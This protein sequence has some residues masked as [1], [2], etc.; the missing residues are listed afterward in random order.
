MTGNALG[1]WTAHLSRH[2]TALRDL[3]ARDGAGRPVF[4]LEHDLGEHERR[5][6]GEA[7]RREIAVRPPSDLHWLAW[8]VYSSELGYRYAGDE[9]WQTFERETSGWT[10]RGDRR[11]LRKCFKKFQREYRGAVPSGAWAKHFSIICWPITHAILPKDLQ[12]QFA[13]ILFRLRYTYSGDLFESPLR[14]GEKIAS[15]SWTAS[16]RFQNLTQETQLLGQIAAALLLEG[17]A[18]SDALIYPPTL[19]R[20]RADLDHERRTREWMR[21][22]SRA[23][24]DRLRIRGLATPSLRE[25]TPKVPRVDDAKREIQALGIEPRLVLRPMDSARNSWRV[26]LEIPNLSHLL[27]RFPEATAALTGSR[28]KVAGASGRPLA[29][30]RCL[31]D[32]QHIN[33][34]RWPSGDEVLLNFEPSHRELDFLLRTECMLRPGTRWLFRI[35]SDGLAYELRGMRVRP[36]E[37]Y[38]IVS[39]KEPFASSTHVHPVELQCDGAHGALLALPEALDS[40]WEET[41]RSLGLVQSRSFEVWPAGLAAAAWDGDGHGEWF[42]SEHPCLGIRADHPLEGL[43]VSLGSDTSPP[44]ELG[45]M[46]HGEVVFLELDPLPEG[47]HRLRFSVR[48]TEGVDAEVL[49]DLDVAVRIRDV[50]PSMGDRGSSGLLD[51]YLEPAAPSLEQMWEGTVELTILGPVGRA[52]SCQ[53]SLFDVE[54]GAATVSK[55]LPPMK[56]PVSNQVW[57]AFFEKHFCDTRNAKEAYDDARSCSLEFKGDELGTILVTCDRDFVP[58]RWSV[59]GRRGQ[60]YIVRLFDDS[61]SAEEPSANYISFETPIQEEGLPLTSQYDAPPSGGMYVGRVHDTTAAILVPPDIRGRGFEGLRSTPSIAV[62]SRSVASI[63]QLLAS[64][65]LWGQAKLPGELS[66]ALRRRD[67]LLGIVSQ[68]LRL[69]CGENWAQAELAVQDGHAGLARLTGAISQRKEE[70]A[71]GVALERDYVELADKSCQERAD[72]IASLATRFDLV[73]ASDAADGCDVPWLS[74]FA[75]RLASDPVGVEEWAG[76]Q[77]RPGLEQLLGSPTLARASRYLVLSIEQHLVSRA[78]SA[79]LYAGWEWR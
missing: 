72:R 1:D 64:A 62:G 7:L 69:I 51:V 77:L 15:Y 8:A 12:R 34:G 2:F 79:Y 9:F 29:R 30:G 33:L 36:G 10:D 65:R 70:S 22:A 50:R 14:L 35:A 67:V 61:G 68:I 71:V 3:R 66:V 60:D 6:L 54:G 31:Y 56:L 25:A 48:S 39:T 52:V 16:S 32:A 73:R 41:V 49:G 75:L 42:A 40:T 59:H 19:Q 55:Q 74:E 78:G 21:R 46:N 53:V 27:S 57:R 5:E 37:R 45:S 58:L 4:A 28:C 24:K 26:W 44:V 43:S 13:E 11:W 23:A 38:L 20:I 17:E 63:H 47:L 76:Q 18:G